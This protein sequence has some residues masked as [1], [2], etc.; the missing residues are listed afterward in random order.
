MTYSENEFMVDMMGEDEVLVDAKKLRNMLQ[1]LREWPRVVHRK[2]NRIKALEA[3]I[4]VLKLEKLEK[5][6]IKV[7]LKI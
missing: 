6:Y 2:N 4:E 5:T 7:D 1:T 3:T